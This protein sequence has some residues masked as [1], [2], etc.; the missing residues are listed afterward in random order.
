M[1]T[2]K[3]SFVAVI[4]SGEWDRLGTPQSE[5]ILL[6][7]CSCLYWHADK[8]LVLDHLKELQQ[9]HFFGSF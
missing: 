5:S 9:V 6:I 3:F 2:N 1:C 8:K 7:E 4:I